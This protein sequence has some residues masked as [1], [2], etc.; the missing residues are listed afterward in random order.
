M[1]AAAAAA[2]TVLGRSRGRFRGCLLGALLGDCLGGGFEAFDVVDLAEL[3]R[4][5]RGLRPPKAAADEERPEPGR[6]PRTLC[7]SDDTAMAHSIVRSLLARRDFD[8]VDMAKR[9]AEEYKKDPDRTYGAGVV[10]VFKKLLSPKCRDVFEPARQQFNG[11]GS[12]GN[13]G[14]MRVAGISLAY[15]NIQDVK[16]FAKL[17]AELTH[18]NSLGYNGAILQALAVH[19]ALQGELSRD[20][21]LEQLIS[22][23]E[24]VEAD[25]K[26]VVDARM[27]GYEEYPFSKRL[28][29]IKEFLEQ[30][31]VSKSD[32]V[33]E[34]GNGV[35][36]LHSVP[37]AIYS[38]LRCMESH[39]DIPED[40]NN[41]QRTIIYCISLGGDTDTIATMAGAIA[42]A[43][44]GEE[45]VPQSWKHS[46]ESFEET[47]ALADSLY[48]LYCQQ[49]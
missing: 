6:G 47:E 16:K 5:V 40:F 35:A 27:L 20:K 39:P 46:C 23:M 1:A 24:A 48:N 32:V 30:S 17:S 26:S 44:Y 49:A 41:L 3:L 29:K 4:F 25:D 43:Y 36:A 21:F 8:E 37:T 31:T 2:G 42:G 10:T 12:Y 13:G 14:A 11:K 7:Y 22:H 45:Q 9:F 19:Y 18:A 33:L 38:F 15:S 34:L 28:K